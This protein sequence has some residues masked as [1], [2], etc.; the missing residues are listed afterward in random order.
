MKE[1]TS[2]DINN[3]NVVNSSLCFLE[4]SLVS[5]GYL[6]SNL[7]S[8][9]FENIDLVNH[10]ALFKI[11]GTWNT[12]ISDTKFINIINARSVLILENVMAFNAKHTNFLS[13]KTLSGDFQS[14][15]N[16]K[17]IGSLVST[18]S[19]KIVFNNCSFTQIISPSFYSQNSQLTI[20]NSIFRNTEDSNHIVSRRYSSLLVTESGPL[21]LNNSKF[22]GF[23]GFNGAVNC[24][25]K[26]EKLILLGNQHAWI[27]CT[28][29]KVKVYK[30]HL[31]K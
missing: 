28:G 9:L 21:I 8:M 14:F 18:F 3:I 22:D 1:L 19:S 30:L 25:K 27:S 12:L 17:L 5:G 29:R 11:Y 31:S 6:N 24:K 26:R 15:S 23:K 2:V 4:I 10:Q 20:L 13:I 7:I 16:V